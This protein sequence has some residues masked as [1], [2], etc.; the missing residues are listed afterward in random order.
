MDGIVPVINVH[1]RGIK[2]LTIKQLHDIYGGKI[3]NW[4]DLGGPDHR[5][6]VVSRDTSS[7]TYEV[8]EKSVLKGGR[9]LPRA[10]IVASNG[11]VVNAV[12]RNRY[13]I[14]YVGIG[15][16]NKRI[17]VLLVG[18][19][20]ASEENVRSGIYPISRPLFMFTNGWPKGNVAKW[21]NLVLSKRGQK[22]V[23]KVGYVS[24]F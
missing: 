1:N 9:V 10:L 8:W 12:S 6:V 18:G 17:H 2:N 22:A 13:A 3:R 16:V 23:K 14:G 20:A 7:G 21:I 24:V 5:I 11:Q 4:K 15:Y 19:I